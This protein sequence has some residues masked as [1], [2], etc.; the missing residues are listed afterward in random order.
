MNHYFSY[1]HAKERCVQVAAV[2]GDASTKF[3]VP[4]KNDF[5]HRGDVRGLVIDTFW[6]CGEMYCKILTSDGSKVSLLASGLHVL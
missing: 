4:Q 1:T 2:V 3:N 5:V 6:K